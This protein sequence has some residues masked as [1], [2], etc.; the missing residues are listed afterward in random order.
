MPKITLQIING[1]PIFSDKEVLES[2]KDGYY[3]VDIKNMDYRTIRQNRALHKYFTFVSEA[4][5]DAGYDIKTVIKADVSW[6][7]ENIKDMM[8]RPLQIALLNKKSTTKL[9]KEEIDTVYDVM[10]R[11]LGERFGIYVPFPS[12]ELV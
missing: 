7:P 8:W 4:L 2:L 11:L 6:S 10:N 12:R 5:N 1:Q 3:E 9:K